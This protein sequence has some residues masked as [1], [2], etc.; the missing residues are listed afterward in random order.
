MSRPLSPRPRRTPNLVLRPFRRR[1]A[2]SLSIAVE[3]S[4]PD[5]SRWLPWAAAGYAKGDAARYIRESMS[6]WSE[7]RAWDFAIRRP[8][9]PDRHIGNVSIWHTSRQGPTGEIGYWVHSAEAGKGVITEATAEILRLGFDE[10]DMH[11]IVLRIAVGNHASERVAE[12]LGFLLEG[13]LREEVRVGDE[14]LDHTIWGLLRHEHEIMRDKYRD[15][16]WI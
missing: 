4:L 1:D 9:N 5:L 3:A 15:E 13:T 2:E 6:A 14:W 7:G 10:L 8:A 16:G 12:K 11:R